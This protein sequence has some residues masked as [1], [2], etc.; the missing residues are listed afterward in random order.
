MTRSHAAVM[1]RRNLRH[2]A[3]NPVAVFNAVLMPI[4]MMLM[5]VYVFGDAFDVGVDYIDYVTPGLMLLAVC[6]GL[7]AVATSVN[8]DMTKGIRA[9]PAVHAGHRV[10]ARVP[11]RSAADRRR[12]R[13]RRLVRRDRPD[14]VRVGGTLLHEASMTS[15][16]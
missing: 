11:G 13:R 9:V 16:S 10:A 14:R 2:V 4:V 12:H 15:T 3:R 6:Y 8:A 7:G 5:F 1:L